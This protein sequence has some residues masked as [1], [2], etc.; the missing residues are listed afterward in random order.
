MIGGAVDRAEGRRAEAETARMRLAAGEELSAEA[1]AAE[2]R[3]DDA[4]T[5]IQDVVRRYPGAFERTAETYGLVRHRHAG[6]RPDR[7][8]GGV[9]GEDD[10][11]ARTVQVTAEVF[12]FILQV[13]FVK[14]RK[15]TEDRD[16]QPAY[17]SRAPVQVRGLR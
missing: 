16:A 6:R 7:A 14:V 5:Q 9:L 2:L 4:L 11:A 12:T 1:A 10:E 8:A 17:R 13:A 3:Q 15:L